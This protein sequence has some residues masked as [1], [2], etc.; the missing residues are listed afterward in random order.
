M[1]YG[2][3]LTINTLLK[4]LLSYSDSH[5]HNHKDNRAPILEI[6]FKFLKKKVKL[7]ETLDFT[8]RNVGINQKLSVKTYKAFQDHLDHCAKDRVQHFV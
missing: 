1:K 4:F 8:I 3:R 5:F 6:I 2:S 7:S